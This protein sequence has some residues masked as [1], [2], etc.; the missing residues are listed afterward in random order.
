MEKPAGKIGSSEFDR[1][2]VKVCGDSFLGKPF[3]ARRENLTAS[4]HVELAAKI[5]EKRNIFTAVSHADI[6][7]ESA[8]TLLRA[9]QKT[10]ASGKRPSQAA[11][12]LSFPTDTEEKVIREH[13]KALKDSA[14]AC[15]IKLSDIVITRQ[16]GESIRVNVSAMGKKIFSTGRCGVVVASDEKEKPAETAGSVKEPSI[17]MLGTA[18]AEG[19]MI[20]RK[21]YAERLEEK[22][23]KSFLQ[24]GRLMDEAKSLLKPDFV[25]KLFPYIKY[26][27]ST[28]EGGIFAALWELSEQTHLGMTINLQDIMIDTL[29]IEI[30]ETLDTDPYVLLS[31]GCMII[32]SDAPEAAVAVCA[33]AGIRA[34]VIGTLKKGNDKTIIN[35][36][37]VR[38]LEPFRAD[39]LPL[40]HKH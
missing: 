33:E 36:D 40:I 27:L 4:D 38:F 37:E 39:S 10:L 21:L 15:G 1:V 26:S 8:Y 14:E 6:P 24:T 23:S 22:Y 30:C 11:L 7:D 20:M 2:A 32:I 5:L 18:G 25:K 35:G 13:V 17:I 31:G 3:S 34:S 29:T 12:T 16:A 28:G 19:A 9:A